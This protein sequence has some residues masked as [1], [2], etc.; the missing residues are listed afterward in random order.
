M[1]R[2]KRIC[3]YFELSL[4]PCFGKVPECQVG[5][6]TRHTTVTNFEKFRPKIMIK[7]VEGLGAICLQIV[8]YI[9]K[10]NFCFWMIS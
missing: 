3:T 8:L 9:G 7:P 5:R 10:F 1:L 4:R 6:K 2:Q